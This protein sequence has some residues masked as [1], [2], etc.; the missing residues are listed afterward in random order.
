MTRDQPPLNP[1][2]DVCFMT[3]INSSSYSS[4][5]ANMLVEAQNNLVMKYIRK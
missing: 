1:K 2:L 3:L 4:E 5:T